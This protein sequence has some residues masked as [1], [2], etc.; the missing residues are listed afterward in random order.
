MPGAVVNSSTS[1]GLGC[2]INTV[3]TAD[4]DDVIAD[5][6][7]ILLGVHLAEK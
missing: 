3:A 4:Q 1:I 5:F 7:N 6:V 2:I